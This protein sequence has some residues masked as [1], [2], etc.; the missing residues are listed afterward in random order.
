MMAKPIALIFGSTGAIGSTIVSWFEARGYDVWAGSRTFIQ[1]NDSNHQYFV[2]D[3][4]NS[5]DSLNNLIPGSVN[6]V[7]WAQGANL[8]DNIRDMDVN[9]HRTMYEANVLYIMIALQTLLEK[10]LLAPSARLCV[11]SSIWQN[12][13]KQDKLSYCV[14]KSALQGLVQSLAVDLGKEGVM[15]NAV[16]PGPLDTPMTHANLTSG[17][18]TE[19]KKLTPLGSL[20]TLDDVASLVGFLCSEMNSG[21]TGQFINAD[22]GFSHARII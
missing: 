1:E 18:I 21:I 5:K 4:E 17:Q 7:V 19:L 16:L 3:P 12:L 22:R 13:A 8:S 6:S 10:K 11:I 20:A 2:F 9:K 14:T 15:I